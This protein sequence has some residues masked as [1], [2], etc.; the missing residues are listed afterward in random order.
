[1]TSPRTDLAQALVDAADVLLV[2]FDG[3]LARIFPGTRWLEVSADLR[4]YAVE[5]ARN[6]LDLDLAAVLGEEPDHVQVLRLIGRHA[7]GIA[8]DA[9]ELVTRLELD[10]ARTAPLQPGALEFLDEALARSARVFVVTNNDPDVV[11]AVLDRH[12]PGLTARLTGV[13]GRTAGRTDDLKPAPD[14]LLRALAQMAKRGVTGGKAGL[15]E[16]SA[17]LLGDSVTDVL[18][19][20]AAGVPVVGV[21]QDAQRREDLLAAGARAVVGDLGALLHTPG[22]RG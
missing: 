9:A 11:P 10:A 7:P 17:V 1:M 6:D 21:A 5:R 8:A 16:I 18:A 15:D 3:P 2:D 22:D 13:H 12:V 19:G 14:L 20:K 4:G